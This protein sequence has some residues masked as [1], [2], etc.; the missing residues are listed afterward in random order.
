M[1]VSLPGIFLWC[2][3]IHLSKN[4]L[5][6]NILFFNFNGEKKSEFLIYIRN[7]KDTHFVLIP[8]IHLRI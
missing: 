8:T 7:V 3:M 2:M 5:L 6:E 1:P 4:K